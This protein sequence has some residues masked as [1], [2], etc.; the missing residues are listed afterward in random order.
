MWFVNDHQSFCLFQLWIFGILWVN[1]QKQPVSVSLCLTSVTTD[2]T[3][4]SFS[5]QYLYYFKILNLIHPYT[6]N[7]FDDEN[8]SSVTEFGGLRYSQLITNMDNWLLMIPPFGFSTFNQSQSKK[9]KREREKALLSIN[10]SFLFF[11]IRD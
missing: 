6:H 3:Y 11:P 4:P 5:A 8:C 2:H 9:K 7:S 1:A 10:K